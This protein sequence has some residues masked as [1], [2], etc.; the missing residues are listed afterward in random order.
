MTVKA[1]RNLIYDG[2]FYKA[3]ESIEMPQNEAEDYANRG[4]V[5]MPKTN[6][7]AP[8]LPAGLPT[9]D[10]QPRGKKK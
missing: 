9:L 6:N 4:W 10:E 7:K 5:V 3:R 2:T 8:D 1:R